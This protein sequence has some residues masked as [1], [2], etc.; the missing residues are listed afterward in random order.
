M[1]LLNMIKHVNKAK[2]PAIILLIDFS[3]A[4]DS[5]DHEYIQNTLSLYGFGP[6]I[7][8]WTKS[9]FYNRE[10]CVL[11]KGFFTERILLRQGVPQGDIIS[12][13]IFILAVEVLLIKINN[14]INVKGITFAKK[15][16]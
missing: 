11:M 12:P 1:N 10:A 8:N 13:Y 3:K 14:T 6:I 4:F 2:I 5:I 9:F 15:E 16:G 7:L